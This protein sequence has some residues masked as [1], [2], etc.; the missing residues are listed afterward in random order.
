MHRG[1][2][3]WLPRRLH[4]PDPATDNWCY[5]MRYPDFGLNVF[6]WIR[7]Y[8]WSICIGNIPPHCT[9]PTTGNSFR[10][11]HCRCALKR[12]RKID[13]HPKAYGPR[14]L[15]FRC[16]KMEDRHKVHHEAILVLVEYSRINYRCKDYDLHSLPPTRVSLYVTSCVAYYIV[17]FPQYLTVN[18]IY[19]RG[20][21]CDSDPA[22]C[23]SPRGSIF[24]KQLR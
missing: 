3:I 5:L 15:H 18:Y 22:G 23:P 20:P 1:C 9:Q 14:Y 13:K 24:G 12:I 4:F 11:F 16:W 21:I 19:V 6:C 2:W 7:S 10:N 8:H 17:Y